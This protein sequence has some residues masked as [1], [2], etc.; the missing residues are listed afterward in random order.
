MGV[1]AHRWTVY[2]FFEGQEVYSRGFARRTKALEFYWWR[3]GIMEDGTAR[4]PG[5][6]VLLVNEFGSIEEEYDHE[7]PVFTHRQ[8]MPVSAD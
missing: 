7:G 5:D 2:V 6:T 4:A 8:R 1:K 3:V